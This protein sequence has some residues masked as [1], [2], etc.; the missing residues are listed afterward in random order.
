MRS[1]QAIVACQ[2]CPRLRDYCARIA[3]EKKAAHRDDDLL[4][5]AR[6]PGSAIRTRAC[7]WSAWR[8][9]RTARTAPGASFTGDGSGDFLMARA[10][11]ASAS[12]TSRPRARRRRPARCATPTSCRPCAARRPTTSRRPTRS[13]AAGA[14]WRPRSP[15]CPACG[16]SSRWA[17]SATTP[18]WPTWPTL[19]GVA[20]APAPGVRARQRRAEL[21]GGL[22][23]AARL[24]S[25]EPPEHQHRQADAA[26]DARGVRAR[27]WQSSAESRRC[28]DQLRR[29]SRPVEGADPRVRVA[30]A[31]VHGARRPRASCRTAR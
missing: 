10:P 8:R 24:L 14:T 18:T 7:C 16:W 11:R 12:P 15:P 25:P 20:T 5:H 23:A 1:A 13:S 4:G 30:Q 3:R 2:D 22:A 6:C 21:G 29:R 17:R 28:L 9:P 26:D 31:L 19:T 27:A